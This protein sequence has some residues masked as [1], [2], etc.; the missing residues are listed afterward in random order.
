MPVRSAAD[1]ES[2]PL[3]DSGEALLDGGRMAGVSHLD[4]VESL[5]L[6][7]PNLR[8]RPV[9]PQVGGACEPAHLVHER[10]DLAE[11]GERL[12]HVGGAPASS[13]A[14]TSSR[15]IGT[16]RSWSFATICSP[17]RRRAARVSRRNVCSRS[18]SGDRNSPRTCSSPQGAR[19][20]NSHPGMTRMPS[21]AASYVA[22]ATPSVVSWSVSANAARSA[23]RAW[24][25]TSDGAHS[26]SETVEWQ[27]KSMCRVIDLRRGPGGLR[28]AEQVEQLAL[29]ELAESALWRAGPDG[30]EVCDAA[31]PLG[32]GAVFEDEAELIAAVPSH[33]DGGK[34][35][36]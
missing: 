22:S 25:G 29:G 36:P 12:L 35:F 34:H 8:F 5:I 3:G 32:P 27:C 13:C 14:W 33:A 21:F 26:P 31:A 24:C 4:A 11:F 23:A 2:Q 9:I 10:G 19:T 15:S 18:L 28:L 17:R 20:L 7:D 16:P 1:P 6:K 30:R